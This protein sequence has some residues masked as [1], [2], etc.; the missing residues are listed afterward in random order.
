[1]LKTKWKKKDFKKIKLLKP[2]KG[3]IISSFG[4]KKGKNNIK[5]FQSGIVIKTDMGEPIV[6]TANGEIVFA[7][8]F[9]GY[10]NMVIIKHN[11]ETYTV[12]AY[13]EAIFKKKGEKINKNEVIAIAGS[14]LYFEIRYKGEAK[15]PRNWF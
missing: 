3:K 8:I 7:D 5:T 9:K 15:N 11:Q 2:V 14:T 6:A 13:L 4:Y 10:G 12:Y 1:M